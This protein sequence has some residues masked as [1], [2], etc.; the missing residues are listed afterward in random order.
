MIKR[1]I[2]LDKETAERL[3]KVHSTN[4]SVERLFKKAMRNSKITGI[5]GTKRLLGKPDFVN[6][7]TKVAVFLDGCF[8]HGHQKCYKEPTHNKEY[9]QN[10]IQNNKKRRQKVRRQLEKDGWLVLAFWECM[11]KKD[12]EKI[13]KKVGQAIKQR[14]SLNY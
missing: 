8:W 2:P 1:P 11:V 10:K 12:V 4:T 6:Q 13:T 7:S 14:L 5:F 9:W 3:S